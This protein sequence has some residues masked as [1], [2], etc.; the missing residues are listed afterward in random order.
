MLLLFVMLIGLD[1]RTLDGLE[2][3]IYFY[4]EVPLYHG[5]LRNSRSSLVLPL[6]L[7]IMPYPLQLVKFSGYD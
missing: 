2:V 4:W 7:S 3:G 6:K 5:K 1:V